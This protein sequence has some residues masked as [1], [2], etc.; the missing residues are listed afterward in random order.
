MLW[1]FSCGDATIKGFPDDQAPLFNVTTY[2]YTEMEKYYI[3]GST[4]FFFW[5]TAFIIAMADFVLIVAVCSWYFTESS[6]KRGDFSILKGYWWSFR[7]NLG[8]L[9]FGSF[10][11]A[12]VWS[13]RLIFEYIERKIKSNGGAMHPAMQT[14]LK[15]MRCCL[16]CCHRFIKYVN[17]NAY[18]Q[19]ALTGENFCT[20]AV[21][22][23]LLILKHS[24]T[25]TFTAGLG[26]IFNMIGKGSV[27]IMNVI[28]AFLVLQYVP[29]LHGEI[30]SPVMP[31][32]VVFI[33]SVMIAS[34]FMS[35]YTTTSVCLLHCLFADVDICKTM[36]YDEMQGQNR[37][38]EMRSIVRV[39]AKIK[40]NKKKI[41]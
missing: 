34:L 36:G 40:K 14:C 12:I 21:N 5:V 22:G 6:D 9:L 33:I 2:T 25:F 19:V 3:Y 39:L 38:R 8:S 16:D 41:Q 1:L 27:A 7:Y 11:I 4:F 30:S 20:A 15:C 26:G 17:K 35:M 18:C 13:I 10:I 23:F 29:T 31:L 37:P 28:A 32:V 24:M